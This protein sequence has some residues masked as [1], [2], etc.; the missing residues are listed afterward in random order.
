MLT[1]QSLAVYILFPVAIFIAALYILPLPKALLR[2]VVPAVE[3]ALFSTVN[4]GP[5]PVSLMRTS[6]VLCAASLLTSWL[7]AHKHKAEHEA[8]MSHGSDPSHALMLVWHDERNLWIAVF[9]LF[10]YTAVWRL[11]VLTAK[12]TEMDRAAPSS[13]R[14]VTP[15]APVAAGSGDDGKGELQ[16]RRKSE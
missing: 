11:H 3:R 16:Q 12:L 13:P 1:L 6:I 15:T 5:V 14:P 8:A 4:I 2:W 10:L 7:G 9:G